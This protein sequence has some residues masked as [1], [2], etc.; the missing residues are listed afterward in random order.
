MSKGT[1]VKVARIPPCDICGED[2]IFDAKTMYGPWANLCHK[3]FKQQGCRVGPGFGQALVVEYDQLSEKSK[4][5][6]LQQIRSNWCDEEGL[7]LKSDE[8]IIQYI[9][10]GARTFYGN[11]EVHS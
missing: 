11:G 6:A 8:E 7:C 10:E 5:A 3:H 9:R 1:Y 4:E 2:A